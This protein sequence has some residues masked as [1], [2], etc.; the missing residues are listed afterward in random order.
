LTVLFTGGE[1]PDDWKDFI[2]FRTGKKDEKGN[3]ERF[4]LPTYMKDVYAYVQQPGTTLMHKTHPL[5]SMAGDLAS[6]KDYYGTE[7]RHQGDNPIFQLIQAG[8]FTAKAFIPFWMKG[9][10]K[11]FERG[12]SIISMAAPLIGIMPAPADRNKTEAERLASKLVADRMPKGSR[13]A[14]QFEQGQLIQHLT[15]LARRDTAKAATEIA[16]ARQ[17]RKI[18]GIQAHHIMQNAR[19][20]P[21]MVAFK[22]LSYEEA[23]RVYEVANGEEKKRLLYALRQ[24]R[25]HHL[26]AG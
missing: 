11:E 5:L 8:K 18:T 24:K 13:T 20:T 12:G 23:Q 4:M 16:Q 14:E 19:L 6:N 22:R 9:T 7:I 2:A 3:P 26:K 25:Y 15:G 10:A 1:P 17:D 21:I